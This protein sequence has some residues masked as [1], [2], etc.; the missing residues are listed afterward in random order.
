MEGPVHWLLRGKGTNVVV[1][2]I[3]IEGG[4]ETVRQ[5]GGLGG[6]AVFVE[7][8]VADALQVKKAVDTAVKT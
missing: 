4:K 7:C 2:D 1:T 5:I 8:D 6:D 3:E